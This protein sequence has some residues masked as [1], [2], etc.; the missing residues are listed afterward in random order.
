MWD[1]EY[2]RVIEDLKVGPTTKPVQLN[3]MLTWARDILVE[4]DVDPEPEE[5]LTWEDTPMKD[6]EASKFQGIAARLNY[7]VVDR[8]DLLLVSKDYS[9]HISKPRNQDW[10]KLK[11]IGR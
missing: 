3:K 6:E 10:D 2:Q 11:R 9:R 8:V 4:V 1:I 5:P 7:L